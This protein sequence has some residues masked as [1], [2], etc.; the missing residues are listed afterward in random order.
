MLVE[1]H[2]TASPELKEVKRKQII[3][4]VVNQWIV[5]NGLLCETI[6]NPSSLAAYLGCELEEINDVMRDK[7]LSNRIWEKGRQEEILN[8]ITGMSISMAMEDRIEA[9]AQVE[10]LKKSQGSHYVPFI[11]AELRQTMDLKMKAGAQISSMIKNIMGGTT[12]IFNINNQNP[13]DE[14][15][16]ESF[17]SRDEALRIIQEEQQALSSNEKN[18]KFIE[19]HYDLGELPE[20][21]ARGQEIDATKEGLDVMKTELMQITDN[22][23]LHRESPEDVDFHEVRRSLELNIDEEEDPE[24]DSY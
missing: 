20:V 6:F 8:S 12:N 23:K 13:E 10:I 4:Y 14:A 1:Y 9:A 24:L 15:N 11:S 17:L 19:E 16:R 18:A 7:L 3:A 22:Y 5:H 2:K 21:C